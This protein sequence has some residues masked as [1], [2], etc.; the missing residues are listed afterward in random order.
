MSKKAIKYTPVYNRKKR[1]NKDGNG[2][3]QIEALKDA[4]RVYF[5]TGIYVKPIYWDSARLQIVKHND[6][7]NL[8]NRIIQFIEQCKDIEHKRNRTN[9]EFSV[10]DLKQAI[11]N[12]AA[13]E[14][15]TVFALALIEKQKNLSEA[16]AVKYKKAITTFGEFA[17][18]NDSFVQLSNK[19]I[20][21]FDYYLIDRGLIPST[22]K[23]Y[24]KT[25][26]K[27]ARLA[28]RHGLLEHN[29]NPFPDK[30]IVAEKTTRY[31]LTDAELQQLEALQ[32]S[33][34]Q[35]HL[36]VIRDLFLMQCYTGLRFS[37]ASRLSKGHIHKTNEGLE[38]RMI[39]E[40][41]NK[42]VSLP[43]A[44]LFRD[45]CKQSRPE[46]LIK[47]YWRNDNKP[48]FL[49]MK[50]QKTTNANNQYVNRQLKDIQVMA[51]VQTTLTNHVGRHTFAT[52][53]VWRVPLPV[54]QELL[55]H[56]K[57]ETT[58]IYIHVGTDKVKEHL[59]RI[60]DWI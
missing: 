33:P 4:A 60:T 54:V 51:G 23:L 22:R 42:T 19:L 28:V 1:L 53:L 14:S 13:G 30:K 55:Q 17:K 26:S 24:F 29:K 48:L 25:L 59:K 15:F 35:Y 58:M 34:A 8:N 46:R 44:Y 18:H 10:Y 38:I 36:E 12:A 2:L 47:K 37:D 6:S 20:D 21:E 11:E 27:Y 40:K 52:Y 50:P 31:S 9:P 3:V 32:F 49:S 39:S 41:E 56:S 16:T 57:V 5:S 7:Y 43:L 45:K